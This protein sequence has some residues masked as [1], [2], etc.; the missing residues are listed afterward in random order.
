MYSLALLSDFLMSFRHFAFTW[1]LHK[2]G[3]L[4]ANLLLYHT[5][6]LNLNLAIVLKMLSGGKF[7]NLMTANISDYNG[8]LYLINKVYISKPISDSQATNYTLTRD[9]S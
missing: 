6:Q 3:T 8:T 1:G 9:K 4:M 2:L 7:P 5:I